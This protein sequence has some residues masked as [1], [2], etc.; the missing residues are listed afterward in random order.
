MEIVF[1]DLVENTQDVVIVTDALLE[2]PGPLIRYVNPAFTRLTGWR[3]EEVLGR[4]PRML[5]GPGTDRATLAAIGLA[6]RR[7]ERCAAQV[8]NYARN[9]APYWVDMR[10]VPLLG[11][12]GRMNGF[13]AIQRDVTLIRRRM[14]ELAHLTDRDM[15][16][17]IPNRRAL[18]RGAAEVVAR[19]GRHAPHKRAPASAEGHGA[20]GMA[21]AWLDIDQ[22]SRVNDTFGPAAGD[23]VLMGVADLLAENLRRA[24]LL[25]RMEGEEFAICMPG[26]NLAEAGAVGDRLRAAIAATAFPTEAGPLHITCSLAICCLAPGEGLTSLLQRVHTTLGRAKSGGRNQLALG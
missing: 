26:L 25:G 12:H 17:G 3:A 11:A 5:H 4:S 10:I 8:M 23:A 6:L 24:D 20:Q 21:V 22:F 18:M 9:G 15:L 2:R 19:L 7:G 1:R 14:D 16:T 13:A